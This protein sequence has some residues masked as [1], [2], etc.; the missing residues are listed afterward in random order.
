MK[1]NI[2]IV[3]RER[4][5]KKIRSQVSGTSVKPRLSVFK[6]NKYIAA[7]LIDDTEGKTLA[8]FSSMSLKGK[9]G[10]GDKAK[11]VGMEL[12]KLAKSKGVSKVVFDRGGFIY[13]GQVQALA[14]GAREGGL[15]F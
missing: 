6:S 4:R 1:T 3:K 7:Q 5:Q 9:K 13:T 15:E 8:A 2:K 14:E 10:K 12:A 11:E